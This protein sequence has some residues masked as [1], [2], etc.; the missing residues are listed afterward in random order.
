VDGAP[1]TLILDA[2]TVTFTSSVQIQ[3]I[4]I[5]QSLNAGFYWLAFCQQGTAPTTASYL[6]VSASSATNNMFIQSSTTASGSLNQGY[7]VN[8]TTGAFPSTI[9][10]T[11]LDDIAFVW[12]RTSS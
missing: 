8:S 12:L 3:Q 1:D 9:S 10:A 6:G 2:G 4:T 7:R 11:L 5:S